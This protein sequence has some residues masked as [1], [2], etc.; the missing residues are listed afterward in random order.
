MAVF[1]D[2]ET[3]YE[4]CHIYNL[5]SGVSDSAGASNR[6]KKNSLWFQWDTSEIVAFKLL[7]YNN[8][9]ESVRQSFCT[10]SQRGWGVIVDW[11][12]FLIIQ[13]WPAQSPDLNV[14]F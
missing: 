2:L 5:A 11:P 14:H 13:F 9:E 6:D 10:H 7:G 4:A 1:Q 3:I 12:D 8:H